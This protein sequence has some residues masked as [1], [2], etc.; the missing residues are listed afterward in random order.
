M[1]SGVWK[2]FFEDGVLRGE[3]EYTE[4]HGRYTEY[5][6]SGKVLAE[7]PKAGAKSVGHWRYFSEESVLESEGDFVGG[8]RKWFMEEL[9]SLFWP[10]FFGRKL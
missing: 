7:G 4:D 5:H 2:T 1:R 9:L 8:E 3:I 6:H 10:D